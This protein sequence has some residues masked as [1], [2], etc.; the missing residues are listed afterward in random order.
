MRVYVNNQ[1][2]LT[3]DNMEAMLKRSLK[4]TFGFEVVCEIPLLT[5]TG[6]AE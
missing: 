4:M 5:D 6:T 1:E 3:T 2:D